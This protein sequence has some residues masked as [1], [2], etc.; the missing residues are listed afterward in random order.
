MRVAGA[1]EVIASMVA[2]GTAYRLADLVEVLDS[3]G[4]VL[5]AADEV[6]IAVVG[7]DQEFPQVAETVD[8]LLEGSELEF[9]RAV[10]VF[11]RPVVLEESDV[12][13]GCF[14][15][16]NAT[17]LVVHLERRG[18]H[19]V[20]NSG[21]MDA[22]VEVIADL[23]LVV[24]VKS[25]TEKGGDLLGL[26]RVN[27]RSADGLVQRCQSLATT[28]DDVGGVLDLSEAPAVVAFEF[29]DD[30]AALASVAVEGVM[31][32]SHIK[33]SAKFV[34]LVEV[35][36]GNESV[37]NELVPDARLV[38]GAGETIVSVEIELQTKRA[39]SRHA[40]VA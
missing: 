17:E 31:K 9:L 38:Q 15:S 12:V 23:R 39:P 20:S 14:E 29:S 1:E 26:D 22:S 40:Q 10:P 7:C 28:K 27:R 4:G 36:D 19:M 13:Y 21:P 3:Y 32:L 2:A 11:H 34:R 24:S 30:G 5:N 37:V 25:L 16:Q 18:A 6:K 35:V 33:A 8:A